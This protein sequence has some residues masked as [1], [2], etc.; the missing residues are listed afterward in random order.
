MST[1]HE[2]TRL[3]SRKSMQYESLSSRVKQLNVSLSYGPVIHQGP[4]TGDPEENLN[5]SFQERL[6][7][8]CLS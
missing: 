8:S 4:T 1:E 7:Y 2:G 3:P 5:L 6:N